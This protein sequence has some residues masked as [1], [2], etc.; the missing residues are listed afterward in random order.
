MKFVARHL[1]VIAFIIPLL[2]AK[3]L[4]AATNFPPV[5]LTANAARLG[6]ALQRS[7]SLMATSTPQE[8][9]TVRVCGRASA[10][11]TNVN[12]NRRQFNLPLA[13]A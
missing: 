4:P 6:G 13:C 10:I 5:P 7:L 11:S 3:S 2:T 12:P 1:P 9:H 8:P